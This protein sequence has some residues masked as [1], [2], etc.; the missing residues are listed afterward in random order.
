MIAHNIFFGILNVACGLLFI[1]IGLPLA[2]RKVPM[3]NLYGF[4]IPK[5]FVSDSLWYEINCYGGR[6]L[7]RWS[8]MIV[9]IGILYFIFPVQT[10]QD[11]FW[12]TF[13]AVAPILVCVAVTLFKTVLY[14][15]QL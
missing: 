13:L 10:G 11:A 14:A 12:G 9:L 3:N 1:L 5:A 4:R 15:R 6:Q 2:F 7:V 8:I